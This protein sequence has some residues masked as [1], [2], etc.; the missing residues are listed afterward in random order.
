MTQSGNQFEHDD[1]RNALRRAFPAQAAPQALRDRV[2]AM[3]R[4]EEVWSSDDMPEPVTLTQPA[5]LIAPHPAPT[6]PSNPYARIAWLGNLFHGARRVAV[7]ACF[8]G[9]ALGAALFF[10]TSNSTPPDSIQIADT[11]PAQPFLQAALVHHDEML[12]LPDPTQMPGGPLGS[13]QQVRTEIQNRTAAP[14]P[15]ADIS[16]QGWQLVGGKSCQAADGCIAQIFYRRGQQT[17]SVFIIPPDAQGRRVHVGS[18]NQRNHLVTT[19]E[20][21]PFT[22]CVVGYS[23]DG[24]LTAKEV[25]RVADLIASH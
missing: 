1:L 6:D 3:L 23:P 10:A 9:L 21:G 11:S 15:E 22:V 5:G 20:A 7:A 14:M 2:A 17:L 19:R 8:A 4:S 13:L 16:S 24:Q 25:D 18:T 12:Q